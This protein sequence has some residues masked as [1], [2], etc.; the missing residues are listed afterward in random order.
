MMLPSS[1]DKCVSGLASPDLPD[2]CFCI[3][4]YDAELES[5]PYS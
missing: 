2:E 5:H 4:L 3:Y 1:K